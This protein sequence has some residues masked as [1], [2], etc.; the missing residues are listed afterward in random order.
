[1]IYNFDDLTFQ[2]LTID[3]Y[4]HREGKFD[5]A[6]RPFAALSFKLSGHCKFDVKG[7]KMSLRAGDVLFIPANTPYT[8]EYSVGCESIV[9]HLTKCNYDD[10]EYFRGDI[11]DVI[12]RCFETMLADWSKVRSVSRLKSG[13]YD[14][15]D[16]LQN[17]SDGDMVDNSFESCVRYIERNMADPELCLDKVC[18][19]GYISPSGLYRCF[20]RRYGVSPGQ[21]LLRLRLA[22]ALDL[23]IAG[24][25]SVKETANACGFSDEKY[26]S[27]VFKSKYGYPPSD[28]HKKMRV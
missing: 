5:I 9:I 12:R 15:L 25:L 2:V 7:K 3:K 10:A 16:R 14:V 6:S 22:N 4:Y 11:V 20:K 23:L 26:F 13:I 18:T 27:R 28:I 21:Y 8:A 19:H 24:E 1:M 17:S